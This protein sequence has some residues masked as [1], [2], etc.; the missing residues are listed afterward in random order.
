MAINQEIVNKIRRFIPLKI[1]TNLYINKID[2]ISG[3]NKIEVSIGISVPKIIY[4]DNI[5][6][7][8][9]KFIKFDNLYNIEFEI[10]KENNVSTVINHAVIYDKFTQKEKRLISNIE[11]IILDDI[12]PKLIEISLIKDNLRMIYVVLAGIRSNKIFTQKEIEKFPKKKRLKKYISFLEQY[13]IIRKNQDGDYVEGNIPI[14]LHKALK[15]KNENEVLKYTFGYVLKDGRKYLK[16]EL[17]LYMLDTFI[18]IA[19]TYYYLSARIGKLI[20]I[21]NETFFD[22][23]TN[24][25]GRNV[26]SSKFVGYLTELNSSNILNKVENMY[27]GNNQILMKINNVLV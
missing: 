25:Y 21:N 22:E 5:Q 24:I 1:G 7:Q 26:N 14:Q 2:E 23:F 4:D 16:E 9:I 18:A 20:Q 27:F 11:N 12:Y 6:K 10:D 17:N 8:Y 13:G 3:T 15:D 19:T